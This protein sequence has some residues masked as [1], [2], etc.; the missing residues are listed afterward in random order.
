M[1]LLEASSPSISPFAIPPSSLYILII[2][3]CTTPNFLTF[4]GGDS[5]IGIENVIDATSISES[6]PTG[7]VRELNVIPVSST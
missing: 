1:K 2:I 6:A 3:F 4:T 7:I 5:H